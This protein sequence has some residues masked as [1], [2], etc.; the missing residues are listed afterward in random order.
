MLEWDKGQDSGRS[1]EQFGL[2]ME[3]L[4]SLSQMGASRSR[5]PSLK[6]IFLN[7]TGQAYLKMYMEGK[8]LQTIKIEYKSLLPNINMYYEAM[9]INAM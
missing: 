9:K 7:G 8:C 1:F 4:T 6:C 3:K 2:K 5:T